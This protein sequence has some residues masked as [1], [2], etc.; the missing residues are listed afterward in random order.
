M[1]VVYGGRIGLAY[2][3][4]KLPEHVIKKVAIKITRSNMLCKAGDPIG[5][6]AMH[7]GFDKTKHV[8]GSLS[9][10]VVGCKARHHL[11]VICMC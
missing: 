1:C 11:C 10:R 2:I 8:A 6:S 7:L 9:R 4:I 5:N 3:G